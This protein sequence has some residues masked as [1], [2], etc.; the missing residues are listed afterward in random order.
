VTVARLLILAL[1]LGALYV[2]WKLAR[3]WMP[4][5]EAA[6]ALLLLAGAPLLHRFS[7][8][9]M[10][11]IPCLFWMI[12]AVALLGLYVQSGR[13]R[14][15]WL[16]SACALAA[17]LT[18]QQAAALLPVLLA[19]AALGYRRRH[20]QSLHS[21]AAP[22]LGLGLA[23]AYYSFSSSHTLSG[24][25]KIWL[26]SGAV[27]A[28]LTVFLRELGPVTAILA[29]GG[30]LL[31]LRHGG[32]DWL[33]R[34]SLVWIASVACMF[35]LVGAAVRHLLYAAP[36]L[37]L[38]ASRLGVS[39][40]LRL[41]RP[42][43]IGILAALCLACAVQVGT[44]P[45]R[46]LRGF[47]EAAERIN[48]LSDRGPVVYD[49][50]H[51]TSFILHRRLDDPN[52]QTVTY[53]TTRLIAG[54]NIFAA[55]DYTP[56]IEEPQ[57]VRDAFERTGASWVVAEDLRAAQTK[58][59]VWFR[60]FLEGP[61][62]EFMETLNVQPPREDKALLPLRVYRYRHPVQAPQQFSVPML[63]IRREAIQF[64]PEQRLLDWG[65]P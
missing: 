30:L 24:P 48:V 32:Y 26:H 35:L 33:L 17:V 21:Y 34:V 15:I 5:A 39:V 4:A 29:L 45:M 56:F 19:G 3:R 50:P 20:W 36:P 37:C 44:L 52:L 7:V 59:Q 63:T 13:A 40:S 14:H 23:L 43:R 11:E 2:F 25:E 6:L 9:F 46:T 1:A 31:A 62:F 18:K 10:L 42:V 16:C 12:L 22:A 53:R 8:A 47:R 28:Q 49:G 60:A 55:R 54:G 41:S 57:A 51:E 64:R 61:D 65:R 38:L 27:P 58:E